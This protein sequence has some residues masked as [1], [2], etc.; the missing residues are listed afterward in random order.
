MYLSLKRQNRLRRS[1]SISIGNRTQNIFP[2]SIF[3][4]YDLINITITAI[5]HEN[6]NGYFSTDII[7][8]E[9]RVSFT[10]RSYLV[11]VTPHLQE[12]LRDDS[13]IF[14]LT[15]ATNNQQVVR[16]VEKADKFSLTFNQQ[17][18]KINLIRKGGRQEPINQPLRCMRESEYKR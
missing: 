10:E 12:A 8:S 7:C 14:S 3:I 1:L 2:S 5:W 9:K 15:M 16:S 18:V 17:T 6:L 4:D 13:P 11:T